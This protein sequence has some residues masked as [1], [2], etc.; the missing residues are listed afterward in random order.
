MTG[1]E[2]LEKVGSTEADVQEEGGDR[3]RRIRGRR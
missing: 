2:D 1:V 3:A